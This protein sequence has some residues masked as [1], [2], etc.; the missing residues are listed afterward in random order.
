[1]DDALLWLSMGFM[2]SAVNLFDDSIPFLGQSIMIFVLSTYS[3]LRFGNA[4]MGGLAFISLLSIVFYSIIPLGDI[5]K[6]IMPFLLMAISFL[7]YWLVSRNKKNNQFRY[8]TTCCTVI[9]I[10]ALLTLYAAGNYFVVRETSNSMFDLNLK[11]GEA[12]PGAWFFWIITVLLPI[13]Y[14]VRGIRKKNVIV[15]RTGL[16]LVAGI[17]FNVRFYYHV[18]PLEVA[19]TIGGIVMILIAYGV[20]KYLSIPKHG[21]TH[22][23][24]N[25]PQLA[26]FL[27]VESLVVSKTFHQ[28]TPT[29]TDKHFDFGGGS[30]GGGG[31]T[32]NY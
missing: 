2:V 14:I 20:T 4:L 11:E 5:A 32:G 1:M 25:D 17:V 18:A 3:M 27:Q 7:M 28:T 16:L 8:Y 21:I 30:G 12:I 13:V 26:G 22:A 24:A 31:S 10:L 29:E 23:E 15:L 9:E 6:I 19:M